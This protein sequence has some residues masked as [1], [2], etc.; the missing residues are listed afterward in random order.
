MVTIRTVVRFEAGHR[1]LG[2]L[3]TCGSQH[4][5]NWKAEVLV[6]G[7]VTNPLGYLVDFKDIDDTIK[8]FDH[9]VI[10]N[11]KDPLAGMLDKWGQKVCTIRGNPTC[12]VLAEGM[13][14]MIRSYC[15]GHDLIITGIR[16]VLWEN[17]DS[18]ARVTWGKM[19]E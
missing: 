10:L 18:Y 15:V 3:G 9:A 5:H 16:V 8:P 19:E 4:G 2:D 11:E 7:T 1:Q 12:E 14:S 6:S 13:V 17:D